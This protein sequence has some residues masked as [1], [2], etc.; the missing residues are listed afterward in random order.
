MSNPPEDGPSE[1]SA[2]AS[3][4][5]AAAAAPAHEPLAC[6]SCRAR[7]LK[8]DRQ[9]PVCARC[10]K[11]GGECVYPESRRK[12][13]FKR[14]NVRELEER[15]AQVEGL[16]KNVGKQRASY[17]GWSEDSSPSAFGVEPSRPDRPQG[18]PQE[19]AWVPLSPTDSPAGGDNAHFGELLGLGQFESL[20]PFEMIEELH[21]VF[22]ATQQLFM[23][24]VHP[25]NYYRAFHSPP[26]MRPPMSLQ[27]AIW[28]LAANG[29]SKYGC[30]HDALYQRAR[31][32]L[33]ADELKGHGEHFITVAHAQA[34][35]LVATDE[36]RCL[37]FTR[38]A[39]SSAR[40][41]RLSGM[42]GL[43]RLD[44]PVTDEER[45]MAPMI[46]P[47]RDWAE[48]EERR[49][50]FWGGY[51]LDC[52]ASISTGWP[53]IIDLDQG[54]CV[55]SCDVPPLTL[56]PT[57]SPPICLRP[58]RHST[59]ARRRQATR[60]RTHSEAPNTRPLREM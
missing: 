45:P 19:G 34:W 38:A 33:E 2:S 12:P 37:R 1:A 51:C 44:D 27:Y 60:S 36:A 58:R 13:A 55:S 4:S 5:A 11:A 42:M 26:H 48:L 21:R 50:L 28:T 31:H 53:S 32:Y 15:L 9:K 41:V 46:A 24:I 47:P 40:S 30:Y 3:A 54:S 56:T 52:Y 14:R 25:G 22:F 7:K 57:R 49:R 17:S 39:M 10:A 6:V 16:L 23:P 43:Q 29:H 8:C 18:S 59:A 20:P 35:A